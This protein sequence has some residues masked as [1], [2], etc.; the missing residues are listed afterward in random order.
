MALYDND[1]HL[2]WASSTDT[3]ELPP[4]IYHLL[5]T[6]PI[7]PVRPGPYD[8]LV[9]LYEDG[10]EVHSWEC[11]PQMVVATESHQ[12]RDDRWNGILNMP[13]QFEINSRG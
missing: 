9:S 12:H 6:F 4:G 7:L 3:L 1:R 11:V 10:H 13:S 2:I 5:H 8:W